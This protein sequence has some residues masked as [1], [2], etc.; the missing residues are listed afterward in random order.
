MNVILV[1][2]LK[3]DVRTHLFKLQNRQFQA[4]GNHRL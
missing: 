1:R 3:T 2:V 4:G